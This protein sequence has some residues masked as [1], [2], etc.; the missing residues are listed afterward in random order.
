MPAPTDAPG[1]VFRARAACGVLIGIL[2]GMP[3][4]TRAEETATKTDFETRLT[5]RNE[6]GKESTSFHAGEAVTLVI[7]IRNRAGAERSLTLPSSQT[8]DVVVHADGQKEVWR[9]SSGRMFAQVITDLAFAPG[10]TRT[11]TVT[12]DQTDRHGARVPPGDYRAVGLVA[13]GALCCRSDPV[14]F[15]IKPGP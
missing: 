14:A 8:H 10:E 2:L 13:R 4:C 3:G 5:L 15:T 7:T 9:W 11:Y 1:P 6:G 12:W